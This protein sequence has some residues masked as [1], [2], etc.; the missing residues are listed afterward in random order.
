MTAPLP[1]APARVL[2][3]TKGLGLGGTEQLVRLC[4]PRFDPDRFTVE[5]AYVLPHKDALVAALLESGVRVHCLGDRRAW[6]RRLR[7]ML[8]D[9]G[10]DLVHT[11]S[12]ATGTVARL[13]RQ[14]GT[15]YV[16][17]EH[18]TWDRYRGATRAANAL[19]L[20]ANATV[21]T[22]SSGVRDSIRSSWWARVAVPPSLEVLHHGMDEASVRHGDEARA[23][24][25][26]ALSL[27]ADVPVIG[28]VANFTPK[29]DHRT[30]VDG[31]RI[32]HRQWPD[33][34]LVLVGTGPLEAQI[35]DQ[36]RT[37]GLADHVMMTGP[38][39]DVPELLPALDVFV[40][41]SLH[42]GLPIS[43]LEAM[44]TGIACVATP[45]GGV[46]EV[47]RHGTD[48]LQV[49]CR[50]PAALAETLDRLLGDKQLRDGLASAG[51]ARVAAFSIATA[52]ER[53]T[54][55]YEQL[56]TAGGRKP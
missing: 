52:V 22:V 16:H 17:T 13:C 47:I 54:A 33:A 48:G 55:V 4:V 21:F 2:W 3:L 35:R 29:K 40:L 9:G 45:V 28:T 5:V 25:R 26:A 43:L 31:F 32:L 7:G 10:Y 27:P 23:R 24:A 41:S 42:E 8:R 12:P 20:G 39:A 30:L 38:R 15:R 46:P 37:N 50:D 36:I 19:T 53:M 11:H 18:N 56:L 51:S 44:A 1:Q 49:P 34:R 6:V 14:P